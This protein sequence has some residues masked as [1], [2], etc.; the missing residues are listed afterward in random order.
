M[1]VPGIIERR[2]EDKSTVKYRTFVLFRSIIEFSD[3]A[4]GSNPEQL[5]V[6][7]FTVLLSSSLRSI[8]LAPTVMGKSTISMA[9]FNS[10][11]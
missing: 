10:F 7:Y 3:S 5:K 6:W 11:L 9:I 1:S 2:E 8:I 4:P